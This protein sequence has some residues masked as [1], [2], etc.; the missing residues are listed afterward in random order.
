M[1]SQNHGKNEGGLE[2][3]NLCPKKIEQAGISTECWWGGHRQFFCCLDPGDLFWHDFDH[4]GAFFRE[5]E[6]FWVGSGPK[7]GVYE[8]IFAKIDEFSVLA[9]ILTSGPRGRS[10]EPDPHLGTPDLASLIPIS[11]VAYPSR[12]LHEKTLFSACLIRGS[13]LPSSAL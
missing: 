12:V 13:A 2:M 10:S 5:P 9:R 4:R 6:F 11:S 8:V 7:N 1:I 3:R